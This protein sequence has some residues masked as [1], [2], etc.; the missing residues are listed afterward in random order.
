M[1]LL[2]GIYNFLKFVIREISSMLIK[3]IFFIFLIILA[4]NYFSKTKKS[5][6][7]TKTYLKVDL[8]KEFKDTFIQSPLSLSPNSLNFYQLLNRVSASKD[9][10][11]ILGIILFLDGNTLNRT[12]IGELGE[13]LK[14][15]KATNKPIYSYSAYMDNNTLLLSSYST[16]SIMP[17]S[18]ST[19][20]NITGYIKDLPYYKDL[21][22]KLGIEVNVVHV[23]DFKTYG[24]NYTRS[25]MSPE[26]RL[27]LKRILNKG[28][29]FFIEDISKNLSFDIEKFNTLT[30]S[31]DLMGESSSILNKNKLITSLAY[32]EN[33]KKEKKIESLTEI[34]DYSLPKERL[35]KNQIAI[36]YAEGEINY[37]S[38]RNPTSNTITPDKII[39]ILEKVEKDKNIKGVILRVNSPGGSALASDIIYNSVKKMTK[40]VYVSIGSVAA[41]G[42]YYISTAA[43]KIFANKD[44]ITGSIGVVSLIPNFKKLSEKVGVN[45]EGISLG[46]FADLY[47]L[48]AEM[49]PERKEKIYN[50]NLKVYNEFLNKVAY[51]RNLPLNDVEKIAQGKV[52]LGEEAINIGLVDSIGGINTTIETL[53]SDLNIQENYSVTEIPYEEDFKSM[54]E[55]NFFPI[56]TLLN[57]RLLD[58]SDLMKTLIKEDEL[59]FK[60]IL[61]MSF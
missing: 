11:N 36:I 18:E 15:F 50:S 51:G 56:Q 31:G 47:S 45:I 9:D 57:L 7:T 16:E 42:G 41:S 35:S 40:P 28:Y 58:K 30:L 43:T 46:K 21:T 27:D 3:F 25:E 49:T 10:D 52:W 39:P 5:P 1:I 23:G 20:V 54:F 24:E 2:Q 34:G 14:K 26:N 12:Q 4:F 6:V 32:W 17:P 61:Y 29:S 48:T 8:S 38:S 22:E 59:L 53:A 33:F 19:A 60:P 13:C 44:S 37:S 55:S